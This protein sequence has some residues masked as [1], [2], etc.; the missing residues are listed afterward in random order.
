MK[1]PP[2]EPAGS[3]TPAKATRVALYARVSMPREGDDPRAQHPENQLIVLRRHAKDLGLEVYHEYIDRISGAE[4]DRPGL[5][6]LLRDA[7]G[8]RFSLVLTTKVDRFARSLLHLLNLLKELKGYG[9]SV[10][11]TDD[12]EASTDTPHGE[13]VLGILGS[14]AQFER[15][16]ISSRT[17]AGIA[18]YRSEEGRWGPTGSGVTSEQVRELRGKGLSIR[19]VAEQLKVSVGTVHSRLRSEKGGVETPKAKRPKKRGSEKG[20]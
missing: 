20:P 4:E 5:G 3:Y 16:L 9:V 10:R 13:L 19:E 2:Q 11:F 15:N 14:V 12:S 6:Q 7:R 18:R 8:H 1:T 17:K